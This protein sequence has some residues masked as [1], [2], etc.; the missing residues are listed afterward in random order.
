MDLKL[1]SLSTAASLTGIV[2]TLRRLY[3]LN[4]YAPHAI[5]AALDDIDANEQV[6]L[7]RIAS[8]AHARR[9]GASRPQREAD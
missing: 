8:M 9:S 3:H 6:A 5:A 2:T 7:T 4:F 1:E